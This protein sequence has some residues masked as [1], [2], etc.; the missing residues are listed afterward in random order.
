[1]DSFLIFE[2]SNLISKNRYTSIKHFC[3]GGGFVIQLKIN[4]TMIMCD[5]HSAK[6]IDHLRKY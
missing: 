1:M 5:P 3:S 2:I 6:F 4:L